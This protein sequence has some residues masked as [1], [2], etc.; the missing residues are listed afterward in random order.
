M[1]AN[2]GWDCLR[3][4]PFGGTAAGMRPLEEVNRAMLLAL[5]V[6]FFWAIRK[7][8]KRNPEEEQRA[9][10]AE[11]RRKARRP[12]KEAFGAGDFSVIAGVVAEGFF[13][14]L[15]RRHGREGSRVLS[16]VFAAPSLT[17]ASPLRSGAC[18]VTRHDPLHAAWHEQGRGA[19]VPADQQT[20][21]LRGVL[22]RP[23][24]GRHARRAPRRA[25]HCTLAV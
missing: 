12:Y 2:A 7:C 15:G 5:I 1:A 14:H 16:Q 24:L 10:A 22:H 4:G 20:R 18:R 9:V 21:R 13:D 19:L 25:R 17:C 8:R 23:L 3:E 6:V 11:N